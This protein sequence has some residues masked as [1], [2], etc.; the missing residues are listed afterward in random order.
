MAVMLEG[1][2]GDGI[3]LFG[4]GWVA[5]GVESLDGGRERRM[6]RRIL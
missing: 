3:L 6:D 1:I 2:R 4:A 5:A